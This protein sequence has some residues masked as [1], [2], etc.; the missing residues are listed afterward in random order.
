MIT[1]LDV[2]DV[3]LVIVSRVLLEFNAPFFDLIF[4]IKCGYDAHLTEISVY[5][6]YGSHRGT[7]FI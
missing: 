3:L 7:V 4:L 1:S 5:H 2:T 6:R